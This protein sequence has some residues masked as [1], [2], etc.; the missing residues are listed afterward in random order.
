MAEGFANYYGKGWL[1][2][3]SAGSRP[4]GFIM[5]NTVEVMR[6]KGIDITGQSSKGLTAVDLR[7]MNWIIVLEASL[8]N[9]L[10]TVQGKIRRANWIVPDPVGQSLD[11]YRAVRDQLELRVLEFIDQLRGES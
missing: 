9:A 5:P 8:A 11:V 4:A 10:P 2:A 1:Q 3:E 6:E 7:R